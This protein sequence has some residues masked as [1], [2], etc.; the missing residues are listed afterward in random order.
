MKDF[1]C[2]HNG[3][4]KKESEVCI[5]FKDL[6][7][8]RAYGVF[9]YLRTYKQ[10]PFQKGWHAKKL[11]DSLAYM[12]I[13]VEFSSD[14]FLNTIDFLFEKNKKYISDEMEYGVKTIISGGV[15]GE[16][17]VIMY[18]EEFDD[19]PYKKMRE[20]G[21]C[22]L[23][24][25][26]PRHSAESKNVDYKTLYKAQKE[27]EEKN[28]LEILHRGDSYVYESGTSNIFIVKDNKI[29]TPK[30]R[31]Y[32]GSTRDFVIKLAEENN[33]FVEERFVTWD[34][35]IEADEVFITASKKEILPV[36]RIYDDEKLFKFDIGETTKR[37][38][39]LFDNKKHEK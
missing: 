28:C 2:Y 24:Y 10:K 5:S 33:F 34:E 7:F 29:I 14:N 11:I 39:K 17:T 23:T 8:Q 20:S 16:A 26:E 30:E 36:V 3:K 6:G 15:D 9:D 35:F 18:L 38:I 13:D 37:L 32:C 22:L 4:W 19:R 12:H 1:I 21:V 31:V 25:R 27:I